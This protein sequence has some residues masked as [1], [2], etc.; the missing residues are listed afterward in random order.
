MSLDAL[1]FGEVTDIG[2]NRPPAA[3]MLTGDSL[4]SSLEIAHSQI[5]DRCSDLIMAESRLPAVTDDD[6]A[7]RVS[8]Y[9]K[10]ITAT[11]KAAEGARIAAKEPYLESSRVVD[12]FFTK[13]IV[14]P[15]TALKRRV[16]AKLTKYLQDKAAREREERLRLE[17]EARAAEESARRE[18]E[19]QA[20]AVRTAA[21]LDRAI[22]AEET[23]QHATA[24]RAVAAEA[25]IAKPAELSRTRGDYGSVASLRSS[26]DF[27]CTDIT[28][29]PRAFM[30]LNEAAIRAHMKAKLKDQPP[31]PIAGINFYEKTSAAVR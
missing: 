1:G 4:R 12:G 24:T 19:A 8:D 29:V 22:T 21:D 14:D 3:E 25:A 30:M 17:R 10:Q 20:A 28:A 6:A 18:A 15:L 2:H 27:E 11:A 16:E 31:A 23:A 26:W 13:G 5:A 7:G 9:I